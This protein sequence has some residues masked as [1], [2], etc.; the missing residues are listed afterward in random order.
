MRPLPMLVLLAALSGCAHTP[1]PDPR[2]TA[3]NQ[4]LA[5]LDAKITGGEMT[6]KQAAT[7]ARDRSRELFGDPL[8]DE[9]WSYRVFLA[10]EMESGRMTPEN[11]AY[12]DTAKV[13]QIMGRAKVAPAVGQ[14][15]FRPTVTCRTDLLGVVRCQ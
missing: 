6:R 3:F 2:D 11:A 10:D 8:M 14:A 15:V 7:S 4:H 12:L 5:M 1:R 9:L 13:N